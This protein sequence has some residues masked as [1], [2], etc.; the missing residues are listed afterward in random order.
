MMMTI[1]W[2]P[3]QQNQVTQRTLYPASSLLKY[4]GMLMY[5]HIQTHVQCSAGYNKENICYY[6]KDNYIYELHMTNAPNKRAGG[7]WDHKGCYWDSSRTKDVVFV[8]RSSS[9][10]SFNH[11]QPGVIHL[12]GVHHC[13]HSDGESHGGHFGKVV[14]EETGIG[15]YGVLGQ[16]LHSGPGHETGAGLIEGDVP[17]WTDAWKNQ[18]RELVND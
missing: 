15:Y 1:R 14:P 16:G 11:K 9:S 4:S 5:E 3:S 7:H 17:I 2:C 13:S 12:S 18:K 6:I 10:Y 8:P